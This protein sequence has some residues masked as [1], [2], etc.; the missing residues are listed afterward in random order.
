MSVYEDICTET[1]LMRAFICVKRNKGSAGIDSVSIRQVEKTLGL[2]IRELSRLLRQERYKPLP[3]RRV[4]IPKKNGKKRPLGIP[5][6]RDRIVQ[7]AVKE[8]IQPT[9]ERVFSEVSYGFRPGRGAGQAIEQ[10][11]RYIEEGYE[12]VVDADIEDFFGTLDH[13]RLMNKVREEISDRETTYLIYHFLKAGVME[14]GRVK[15]T[16]TGTPQGGVISPILANLY[17]TELDDCMEKAGLKIVRYAD[18]FVILCRSVN[19]A[20]YALK[21]TRQKLEKMNLA[22]S[23]EKTCITDTN[24]GFVFLGH[25]FW[26][27]NDTLYTFPSDKSMKAYKQKVRHIT[28]RQQPKNLKMVVEK[29]NPVIRGWGNYFKNGDGKARFRRLDEWTRM[30]LRAFILKKRRISYKVH[31]KYPNSHFEKLG[32]VFL[33]DLTASQR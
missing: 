19:Q 29:L 27:P 18:D 2:H 4:Y 33:T 15:K 6:V 20:R 9:L 21:T 8:A 13:S 17:L 7:E 16:T 31:T 30:R 23:E 32:L 3:A 22:L 11:K 12:Y 26:K 24:Q 25:Q 28:R 1:S 14:E 5:A 10:I